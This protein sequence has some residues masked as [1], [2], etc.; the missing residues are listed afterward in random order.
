MATQ[1]GERIR[2][3]RTKQNMFLRELA[4]KPDLDALIISKIERRDRQIKRINP[5]IINP[6]TYF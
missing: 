3:L 1:F 5:I 4:S 2:K 6:D